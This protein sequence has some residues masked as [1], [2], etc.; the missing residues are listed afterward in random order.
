[1]KIAIVA[2][3][4]RPVPPV[5][6]GAVQIYIDEIVRRLAG[7]H[8]ITLFSPR[9]GSGASSYS[10]KIRVVRVKKKNYIKRVRKIIKKSYYPIIH[11]FNRPHFVKK[12][13]KV[14][15][16][17]KYVL[18]LH[19]ELGE[20]KGPGWRKGIRKTDFF[21]ANSHYTR[22]DAI[23]R[24]RR[25]KPS[26]IITVHLGIDPGKFIMKWNHPERVARLKRKWNTQGKK[27]V[28]FVGKIDKKKGIDTLIEACRILKKKHKNLAVV[29][30]GGSD[31]GRT[32][33]DPYFKR[34]EKRA[35]R[36][37][38]KRG[39]RFTGFVRPGKVAEFY[40]IA[41]VFVCPS[42]WKEP[43]GRVNLEAMASGVPV[44]ATRRGG[45][46]EVV[47]HRVTGYLVSQPGNAKRMARYIDKLLK[48]RK[49]A[50]KMGTA[51]YRRAVAAFSWR[52]VTRKINRVY[53]KV[54]T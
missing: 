50:R 41:D 53:R 30:V 1:M 36:T 31:H 37:L 14:S 13:H 51:G 21:I 28:L 32:R 5:Q 18:N 52:S 24:F 45:V 43:F 42:R 12:L 49:L 23:R 4:T 47:K 40:A 8:R 22:R 3:E 10:R 38:G 27:V 26:K 17:S 2:P 48:N 20:K 34:I 9:A 33:K 7:R 11:T 29:V 6:G 44:V 46:P 15:P 39:V 35:K 19:N 16:K 25:V 54:R